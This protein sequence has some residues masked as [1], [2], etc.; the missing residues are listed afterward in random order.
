MQNNTFKSALINFHIIGLLLSMKFI[1][2]T[3]QNGIFGFL[4]L[5]VSIFIVFVMYRSAIRYRDVELG[6][7]IKYSK[8]FSYLFL[9]YIFGSVVSS[10]V[11]FVYSGYINKDYLEISLNTVMQMYEK[12]NIHIDNLTYSY[13]VKFFKPVP[14]ALSNIFA[15]AFGGCFWSLILASFVK[16]DQNIFEQ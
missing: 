1:F 15:S 13:L 8:A 3:I 9:I 14:F 10:I 7:F 4:S 5:F 6:G 12:M 2:S 11:A 16:K